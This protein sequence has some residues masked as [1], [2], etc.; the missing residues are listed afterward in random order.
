MV[1]PEV[2]GGPRPLVLPVPGTPGVGAQGGC[3]GGISQVIQ[4][5]GWRVQGQYGGL[6]GDPW[7]SCGQVSE[8]T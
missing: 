3:W 8:E 2:T 6:S 5:S 1:I 4:G 7:G